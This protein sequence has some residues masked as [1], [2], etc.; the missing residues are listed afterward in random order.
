[1]VRTVLSVWD[2]LDAIGTPLLHSSDRMRRRHA[3]I[4]PAKNR[5]LVL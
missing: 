3:A 5:F 1:M 4:G 2:C